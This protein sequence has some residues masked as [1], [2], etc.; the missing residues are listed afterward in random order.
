MI[1]SVQFFELVEPP[2]PP[3]PFSFL[4]ALYFGNII[5]GHHQ[6]LS[7]PAIKKYFEKKKNF[8]LFR[9]KQE[10]RKML[11]PSCFFLFLFIYHTGKKNPLVDPRFQ[12]SVQ[13]YY[14]NHF[15]GFF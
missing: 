8:F 15:G 9:F 11:M 3:V 5:L 1:F 14:L 6:T 10:N 2:R 4:P 13:Y 12:W 7:R